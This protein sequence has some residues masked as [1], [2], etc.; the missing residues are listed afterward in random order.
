M[1]AKQP[2]VLFATAEAAPF[3]KAGGLGD[4]AGALPK[5]LYAEGVDI[6]VITPLY[7]FIDRERFGIRPL[8]GA[9]TLRIPAGNALHDVSFQKAVLPG[10]KVPVYFVDCGDFFGRDGLYNDPH[11]GEGYG[12]APL[13][14]ILFSK[15]VVEFMKSG[16]FTPDVLHLNDNQ[17]A[18]CAP[19]IRTQEQ[20]RS[21]GAVKIVLTIHNMEYQGKYGRQYVE[22]AGLDGKL[23]YPGGPFEFYGDFN[24]L[25]A[26]LVYSDILTTVSKGY[27]NETKGSVDFGYGLEGVL[28]SRGADY[29]GILNGTDYSVW[30]P[31]NDPHIPTP[32]GP[33]APEG[34]LENKRALLELCG[35]PNPDLERPV[36]GMISRLVYQKGVDL[37]IQSLNEI[38]TLDVYVTILGS[39]NAAYQEALHHFRERFPEKLALFMAFDDRKA[40][41]IEAGAD[42]YLMPSRYE[43]CGLNQ[44]Y[45][46]RYG[47]IPVVRKTGGLADTVK[48]TAD[49]KKDGSGFTFVDYSPVELIRALKRALDLYRDRESWKAVVKRAMELDF[50]WTQSAREYRDLYLRL[51]DGR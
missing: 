29:F 24:F 46:L 34:K 9:P 41:L 3:S 43:P 13:R 15:A 8:D 31:R 27:R 4:V 6:R 17:T 28:A 23:A 42:I 32:F 49:M 19:L 36:I 30:D 51:V 48:E 2:K 39:G 14:F 7:G 20:N 50:G 12:D 45:S 21:L 37:L 44:M 33:D 1:A 26:G 18:L 47:T 10:S 5:A 22:E 38:L 11:T 35:F 16:I 40:H 25:K